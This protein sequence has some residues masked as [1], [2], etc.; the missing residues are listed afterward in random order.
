MQLNNNNQHLYSKNVYLEKK[1]I[2]R[3]TKREIKRGIKGIH[4]IFIFE[5]VLEGWPT[6]RIFNHLIQNNM[7]KDISKKKVEQIATGNCKVY[8]HELTKT[9]YEYY[10]LLRENIVKTKGTNI[11]LHTNTNLEC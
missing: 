8:A 7:E 1:K 10:I 11:S 3:E 9:Q 4:V 5:K 6:I 2:R